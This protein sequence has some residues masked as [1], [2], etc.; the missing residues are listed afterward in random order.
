[1]AD[2]AQ[3]LELKVGICYICIVYCHDC[4]YGYLRNYN[5]IVG[6]SIISS[7]RAKKKAIKIWNNK[8]KR[9]KP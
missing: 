3:I 5:T 6:L 8:D 4:D 9:I 1:M 2:Y 7:N